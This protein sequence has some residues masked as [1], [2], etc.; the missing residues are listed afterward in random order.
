MELPVNPS[1]MIDLLRAWFFARDRSIV[2]PSNTFI[3]MP[4]ISTPGTP[5]TGNRQFYG[6][7]NGWFGQDDTGQE[8]KFATWEA[9]IS[10]Y[11]QLPGLIGFWPMATVQRSTGNVPNYAPTYT[12]ATKQ[13]F[14]Y[15]GN[16][17][18][19]YLTTGVPFCNFDGT[20]DYFNIGD[21]T[22]IDILGNESQNSKSGLTT[23]LWTQPNTLSMGG[24]TY[25]IFSKWDTSIGNQRSWFIY[26]NDADNTI[27]AN[28]SSNGIASVSVTAT[29]VISSTSDWYFCALRYIPSTSLDI[30]LNTEKFTNTTSIPATIFNST[31]AL[32]LATV[33]NGA[34]GL[35]YNGKITLVALCAN[36]HSD[37][38]VQSVFQQ[39]R[40]L[41]GV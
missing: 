22:D 19:D 35:E 40:S 10:L 4:E 39:S 1:E 11:L 32:Q 31:A 33:N 9:T 20:G 37:A 5:A 6:K 8:Y 14:V 7:S 34:S 36:Y 12:G 26:F 41:F 2:L 38:M 17:M 24:S 25:G 18:F 29:T 15:N 27:R 23:Y 30:Y 28:L 21:N 3:Q 16:P 13:D